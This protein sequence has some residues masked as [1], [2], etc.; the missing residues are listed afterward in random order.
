M[1]PTRPA[2]TPTRNAGNRKGSDAGRRSIHN[3]CQRRGGVG[4][5]HLG[6]DHLRRT[7]SLHHRHRDRKEAQVHR[8]HRLGRHAGHP[9][10]CP[11]SPA[12][13]A[14]SPAPAPTGWR[15]SRAAA[16]GPACANARWRSTAPAQRRAH[17]KT[18]QRRLR[19]DGGVEQQVARRI[20]RPVGDAAPQV[21]AT[22]WGAGSTGRSMDQ[23]V[24][25]SCCQ[26][27]SP[28]CRA[29]PVRS[30][31]RGSADRQSVPAPARSAPAPPRSAQPGGPAR[32][33]GRRPQCLFVMAMGQ[34][35]AHFMRHPPRIRACRACP[36][37]VRRAGRCR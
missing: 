28:H 22:W 25:T 34:R 15:R 27:Q 3:A 21:S 32:R 37:C 6:L 23:V 36:A 35:L 5:Q 14:R 11:G 13:W 9:D 16:R 20:Q 19:G 29:D 33:H 7:Q 2:A 30:R 1:A 24:A 12:R 31:L 10:R 17:D 8:D 26:F 18:H 4:V